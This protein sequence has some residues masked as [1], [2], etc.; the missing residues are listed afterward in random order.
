MCVCRFVLMD[1][2]GKIF[3]C[4]VPVSFSCVGVGYGF[5]A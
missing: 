4:V 1:L 5:S 2:I 3:V